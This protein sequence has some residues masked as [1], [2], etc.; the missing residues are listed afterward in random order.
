MTSIFKV[1]KSV[2]GTGRKLLGGALVRGGQELRRA[3]NRVTTSALGW[4]YR[5]D[6]FRA[7]SLKDRL[8]RMTPA[9]FGAPAETAFIAMPGSETAADDF[10][11]GAGIKRAP[12]ETKKFRNGE[13]YVRIGDTVR[14][15]TV[16]ISVAI[17]RKVPFGRSKRLARP[18]I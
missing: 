16:V 11:S 14:N 10:L 6:L 9:E 12:I 7:A 15:K 4:Q 1:T 18:G 5:R 3:A 17:R 8:R 2:Q 13:S